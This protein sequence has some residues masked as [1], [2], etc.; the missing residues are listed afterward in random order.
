[1]EDQPNLEAHEIH[2]GFAGIRSSTDDMEIL[3]PGRT[4]LQDFP[5]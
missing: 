1:M 3:N 4:E 2:K 5:F